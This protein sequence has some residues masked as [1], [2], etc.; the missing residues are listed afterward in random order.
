MEKMG[1]FKIAAVQARPEFLDLKG[2][3][4]KACELIGRVGKVCWENYM[5]LARYALPAWGEQIH[6][7]PTW[8]RGEPW[9]S[10]LRH[11]AKEGRTFVLGACQ[12]CRKDDIPDRYA[13]KAKDLDGV[14]GWLNPGHS[15][16]VNPDGRIIAGPAEE[17]E[18][19]L[20]AEVTPEELVGPRWQLDVAGH[21]GRPDVFELVVHQRQK[22][23]LRIEEEKDPGEGQDD[24]Q[25]SR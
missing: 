24:Y 18:T 25:E 7:A 11:T 9:L 23:F 2:T 8:D 1:A 22:P 12:A 6:A 19:I 14:E 17:E 20:Y 10:T 4:E 5:P 15:V 13:F 3:V 21:Y 16:T